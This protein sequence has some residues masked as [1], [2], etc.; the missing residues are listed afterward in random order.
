MFSAGIYYN[1]PISPER[2]E[3]PSLF[4]VC[5][6]EVVLYGL[7]IVVSVIDMTLSGLSLRRTKSALRDHSPGGP[8]ARPSP[9]IL[10]TKRPP[11]ERRLLIQETMDVFVF[12]HTIF[13]K[14][15]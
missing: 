4:T 11:S 2:T 14:N 3:D 7:S 1:T 9:S 8:G 6:V 12:K 15:S 10:G 13:R 5:V